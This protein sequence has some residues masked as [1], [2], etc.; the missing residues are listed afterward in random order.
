MPWTVLVC[1][2]FM[3]F[4][5][6]SPMFCVPPMEH[7]LKEELLLTHAQTGLLFTA[8]FL[9]LVA[10]AIPGGLLADRI[11]IKKAAGIGA[12]LIVI[13]TVLRGTATTASSLIT[14]TLIYGI[15]IGLSFPNLPKLV[16]V[17]VPKEKAGIATGIFTTGIMVGAA[18]AL[19]L[20]MPVVFPLAKTFQGVFFIWSIPPVVAAILWWILVKEPGSNT[21]DSGLGNRNHALFLK[22]IRNKNLWLVSALLILENIFFYNWSGWT[23]ALTMLK[24][25][26]PEL[27]G[28]IASIQL[29]DS[30][31]TVFL[32]PRLSYRLCLRKPFLWVTSIILAVTMLSAIYVNLPMLWFIVVV[33]GVVDSARLVT[34]LALPVELMPKEE[35]GTASGLVLSVG[36]TG[37]IIGP[38]IGGRILDLTESL[39]ISLLVLTGIS[40]ITVLVAL[41]LPETGNKNYGKQL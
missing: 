7:I 26:T 22:V 39:D 8:P 23:P 32:I 24:G 37:S 27:A 2:F 16:S 10:L 19:A 11:G 34:M 33:V 28:V 13:G 29:W 17:W 31:P 1:A 3:A 41:K 20:T 4:A 38:F 6:Y 25:A 15:G 9:M 36:Y 40:I 30:I 35:V 5:I 18:L 12:I 21:I 14:F